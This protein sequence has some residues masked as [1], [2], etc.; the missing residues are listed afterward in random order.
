MFASAGCWSTSPSDIAEILNGDWAVDR[1]RETKYTSPFRLYYRKPYGSP[2]RLRRI[3]E[4]PEIKKEGFASASWLAI[5]LWQWVRRYTKTS[6]KDVI[7]CIDVI[8][9]VLDFDE[10]AEMD[11]IQKMVEPDI[12]GAE[13]EVDN[14]LPGQVD[15]LYEQMSKVHKESVRYLF[16]DFYSRLVAAIPTA[17]Q[18]FR[19]PVMHERENRY[20][21]EW[22]YIWR[23][24]VGEREMLII[25]SGPPGPADFGVRPCLLD[26]PL[27]TNISRHDGEEPTSCC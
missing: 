19:D 9:L 26:S 16:E 2:K 17:A 20:I 6:D 23:I 22:Q 15:A 10:C 14:S 25:P 8:F 13:D 4:E 7:N 3:P 5:E 1:D 12:Y 21:H 27:S 24:I 18:Y 11:E